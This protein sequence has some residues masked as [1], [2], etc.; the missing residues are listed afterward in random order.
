MKEFFTSVVFICWALVA[1]CFAQ[2]TDVM[3]DNR[4]RTFIADFIATYEAAYESRKLDYIEQ[5]FSSNALII[6]ETM[7]LVRDGN[8]LIPGLKKTRPYH[9]VVEDKKE[10]IDRLRQIFANNISIKLSITGGPRVIR[11]NKYPEIYGVSFTQMWK[12]Q[13]GG[14]N[15]ENQMPGYVFLL[16]DFK[17]REMCPKIYVRTWQPVENIK[18]PTDKFNIMDFTFE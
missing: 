15:L 6:T 4:H 2:E 3:R 13:N 5:F 8:E 7:E 14:D 11:H 10:Y 17:G 12:D 18:S 9:M 16:I 1:N